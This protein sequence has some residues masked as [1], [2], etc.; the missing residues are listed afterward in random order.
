MNN[1]R[2]SMG[3]GQQPQPVPQQQ[4]NIQ[5]M[6]YQQQMAQQHVQERSASIISGLGFTD[7]PMQKP[8]NS[9]PYG[10]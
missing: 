2:M 4:Q 9:N 3:P 5:Q 8:A 10:A 7:Q 1:P 6:Q